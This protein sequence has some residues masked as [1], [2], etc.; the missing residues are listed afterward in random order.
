MSIPGKKISLI[1]DHDEALKVW[2]DKKIKN[3]DLVH[4]DA[5]MD[6][7]VYQAKPI[8]EVLNEARSL[9]GLKRG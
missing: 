6:F 9:K 7:G 8:E 3:L 1:E 4:I 2:I 5:H